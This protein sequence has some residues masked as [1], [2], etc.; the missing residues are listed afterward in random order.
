MLRN[1]VQ[2]GEKDRVISILLQGLEQLPRGAYN[3]RIKNGGSDKTVR[4]VH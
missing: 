4:L 3:L 2:A 1:G